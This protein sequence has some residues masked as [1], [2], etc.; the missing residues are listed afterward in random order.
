MTPF[1]F[2]AVLG[3]MLIGVPSY[4]QAQGTA[5]ESPKD[6]AGIRKALDEKV[7]LDYNA[8]SLQD[9][10]DHL[11]QKTKIKFVL[12]N[13]MF[14]G[15]FGPPPGGGLR[16][17]PALAGPGGPGMPGGQPV[18]KSDNVKIRTVLQNL[19]SPYQLTYVILRDSVLIT[20]EEVGHQRQMQQRVNVDVR[21]VSITEALRRLSD[22]TGVNIVID[23]RQN[24]KARTKVTLQLD[25]VTAETAVRLLAE[26]ADLS[27]APM[28]SVIFVTTEQRAEKLKKDNRDNNPQ[29]RGPTTT[30]GPVAGSVIIP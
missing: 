20:T 10:L 3:L 17:A 7:T 5:R 8:Q 16:G 24:D 22:E 15:G 1:R 19:L 9:A 18:L 13:M 12:D 14:P 28:G 23:P 30:Y 11:Q 6:A 27:W 25:D 2:S 29:P 4:C 21:D 26:V